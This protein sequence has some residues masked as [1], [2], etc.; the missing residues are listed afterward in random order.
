MTQWPSSGQYCRLWS[1]GYKFWFIM[2]QLY[3]DVAITNQ[4]FVVLGPKS[5]RSSPMCPLRHYLF[6]KCLQNWDFWPELHGHTKFER[7]LIVFGHWSATAKRKR[8]I[9]HLS[10]DKYTSFITNLI[11]CR[12]CSFLHFAHS[13]SWSTSETW[14]VA[15]CFE[16]PNRGRWTQLCDVLQI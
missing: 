12:R 4:D 13:G 16:A 8:V 15:L 10:K 11:K 6:P 2:A 1:D 7:L 5:G 3:H 14:E 9:F